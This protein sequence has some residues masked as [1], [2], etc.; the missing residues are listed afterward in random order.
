[1][2]CCSS[3]GFPKDTSRSEHLPLRIVKFCKSNCFNHSVFNKT[4]P[5][6]DHRIQ[7]DWQIR[8]QAY[9]ITSFWPDGFELRIPNR[10]L[11]G[12]EIYPNYGVSTLHTAI[13]RFESGTETRPELSKTQ[14]KQLGF[15]IH[16][17]GC[18]SITTNCCELWTWIRITPLQAL[19]RSATNNE[20]FEIFELSPRNSQARATELSH[21]DHRIRHKDP[22]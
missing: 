6:I 9:R 13:H 20:D 2:V 12:T 22:V 5:R 15:W 3:K 16:G 21:F 4:A 14:R 7:H 17:G 8:K 18:K 19:N 10:N 11:H 1:M